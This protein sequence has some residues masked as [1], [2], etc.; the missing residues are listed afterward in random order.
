MAYLF[1]K[2]SNYAIFHIWLKIKIIF[3]WL[4]FAETPCII[5]IDICV[6]VCMC[7]YRRIIY[8]LIHFLSLFCVEVIFLMKE[9]EIYIYIYIQNN[10]RIIM[11]YMMLMRTYK[12]D[13]HIFCTIVFYKNI[14]AYCSWKCNAMMN[15]LTWRY[16]ENAMSFIFFSFLTFF[17]QKINCNIPTSI[18]MSFNI[19]SI[20]LENLF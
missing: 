15:D 18:S 6:C 12:Y 19:A 1:W 17:V 13:T 9:R 5:Y 4:P 20:W 7:I 11:T 2:Q 8:T 16:T 14:N 10:C 3:K